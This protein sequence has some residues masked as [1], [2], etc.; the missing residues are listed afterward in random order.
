MALCGFSRRSDVMVAA[1][2]WFRFIIDRVRG[3]QVCAAFGDQ[4][5]DH[6]GHDGCASVESRITR[7]GREF[8]A[9]P[10]MYLVLKM[11]VLRH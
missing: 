6:L 9:Y 5:D 4:S 10:T 8:K 7:G 11:S 2:G 3:L 1:D